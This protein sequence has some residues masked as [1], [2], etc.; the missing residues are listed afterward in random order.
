MKNLPQVI[1]KLDVKEGCLNSCLQ[2]LGN[3][4][5]AL[6]LSELLVGPR[7]FTELERA[8]VGISPR[9]LSQ[10]LDDLELHCIITK[11]NFAEA[12]PRI[13]YSLTPK[14]SDFLP[15]LEQMS[16]WGTKYAVK[17]PIF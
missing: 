5:T 13:E 9:T 14:G 7:R 16:T 12:P 8:L 6:I 17:K 3:K 15:I 11:Q 4:W 1:P 10:R 2:V